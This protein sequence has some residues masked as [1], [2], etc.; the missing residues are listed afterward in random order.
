MRTVYL[1]VLTLFIGCSLAF[2]HHSGVM[3]DVQKEV[4]LKGTIKEF[5]FENPHVS[6]IISVPD[7]KGGSTDWNFEAAS[8]RGMAQAGKLISNGALLTSLRNL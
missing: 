2:A 5:T 1:F 6:I 4:T 8:V 7:Q 3:F